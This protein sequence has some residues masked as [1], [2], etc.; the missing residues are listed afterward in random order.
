MISVG[1]L[2]VGRCCSYL[3]VSVGR[4]LNIYRYIMIILAGVKDTLNY[5]YGRNQEENAVNEGD[6]SSI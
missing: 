5:Q 3:E 1:S 2:R 4:R 6:T